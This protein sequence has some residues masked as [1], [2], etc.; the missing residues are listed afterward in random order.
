MNTAFFKNK[1]PFYKDKI[2]EHCEFTKNNVRATL[3]LLWELLCYYDVKYIVGYNIGFDIRAINNLYCLAKCRDI[4]RILCKFYFID[5]RKVVCDTLLSNS[6]LL[7]KFKSFCIKN[8]LFTES[9]KN[10]STTAECVYKFLFNDLQFIESHTGLNDCI[11]EQKIFV[12]ILDLF[13]QY[14]GFDLYYK[15]NSMFAMS[16]AFRQGGQFSLT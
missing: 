8:K 5:L 16:N 9:Q 11:I 2:N 10:V 15:L 6:L 13:R 4:P 7:Q 3:W 14:N 1:I 12:R